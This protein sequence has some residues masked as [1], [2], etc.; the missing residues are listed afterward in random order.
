MKTDDL[1]ASLVADQ[2]SPPASPRRT[3]AYAAPPALLVAFLI[4]MS[5]LDMR[6][7]LGDALQTWRY[8]FK[9]LV[10]ASIAA[11]GLMLLFRLAR[12]QHGLATDG[13]WLALALAPLALS[14]IL[15]I[16]MLP[17]DRWS[18]SAM[19]FNP[20][21]CVTLVPL[22]G[23]VPLAAA[24]VTLRHGAPQS[25][26]GAGAIAG[27]AAGGIGAFIYALHCDNDSPFYVA[28][29]YMAAVGI[30]TLVGTIAGRFYL[31]W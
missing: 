10:S 27:F 13:K 12:P 30:L 21:Y 18:A 15:E 31:R 24:L 3:F 4:F 26:T 25:P 19:G 5:F 23:L 22:I 14:L 6:P 16:V 17:M 28:I 9:V 7:D 2:E 8:L 1:I 20:E 29:W 11:F